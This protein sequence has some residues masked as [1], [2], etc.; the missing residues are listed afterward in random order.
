MTYATQQDLVDRFGYDEIVQLTDRTGG[1]VID[2]TVVALALADADAEIDAHLAARYSLPLA[3]V[4]AI[5]VRIASDIARYRLWDDRAPEEVRARYTDTVR[6]LEKLARGDIELGLPA[7]SA[8]PL[9]AG[10]AWSARGRIMTG[11]IA[12]P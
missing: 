3:S 5:I 9:P 2:G 12:G 7:A 6:V 4:P 1:N 11:E 8:P 10:V